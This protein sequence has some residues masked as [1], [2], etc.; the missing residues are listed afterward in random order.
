M[1]RGYD[2]KL[3]EDDQAFLY[4]L[5]VDADYALQPQRGF[6]TDAPAGTPPLPR[7]W[8]ARYV[9]GLEPVG[10]THRAIVASVAADLWTGVRAD[11]DIV[12]SDGQLQT[13]VVV[14]R[15]QERRRPRPA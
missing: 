10:R 1:P 13:C 8:R 7:G 5:Q 6:L 15:R 4:A 2:W 11:F 14:G 12:D 9:V 3:Y